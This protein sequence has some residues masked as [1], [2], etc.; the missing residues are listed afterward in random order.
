MLTADGRIMHENAHDPAKNG[1]VNGVI[2]SRALPVYSASLGVSGECDVVEFH[3]SPDGIEL[4]GKSGK[5][6]VVPIE[7]KRGE[8]KEGREDEF[9]LALQAMCLE[10]ML[11][12]EIHEGYIF[13]GK[14]RHR[15][16]VEFTTEIR[17][18]VADMIKEMHDY[19]ERKYTPKC[20]K[21]KKCNM[22]SLKDICL[23]RLSTVKSAQR[24]IEETL[25]E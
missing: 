19:C 24:Y 18:C 15:T 21:S 7:Y 17:Q 23:P 13:Y 2:V 22:C 25:S 8:P 14:T 12:C 9:Q 6:R 20:R 5:F 3:P 10:Q 16:K 1:V 4:V 11:C